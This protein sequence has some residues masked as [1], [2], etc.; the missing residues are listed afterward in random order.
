MKIKCC[1]LKRKDLEKH[2]NLISQ[3]YY[4]LCE[5]DDINL[6]QAYLNSLPNPL[7]EEVLRELQMSGKR[8]ENTSL[9][10][11]YQSALMNLDALCKK[12]DTY[13]RVQKTDIKITRKCKRKDLC[14]KCKGDKHCFCSTGEPREVDFWI[15]KKSRRLR[16]KKKK[17]K[18]LR[19]RKYRRDP[20][21]KRC[22]ICNQKG[23]YAKDCPTKHKL[24]RLVHILH[25]NTEWDFEDDIESVFSLDD[26]QNDESILAF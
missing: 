22:Y 4:T 23:H 1:F 7:G 12:Y 20:K 8:L 11:L 19:K 6:K 14:I 26:D 24:V 15:H 2:Y 13:K 17:W 3:R 21:R 18:Y 25:K 16:H 9:G 5:L 10:K